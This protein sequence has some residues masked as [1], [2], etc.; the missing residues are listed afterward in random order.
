MSDFAQ[1]NIPGIPGEVRVLIERMIKELERQREAS[2]ANGLTW[3]DADK[4][5]RAAVIDGEV[6]LAALANALISPDGSVIGD[7]LLCIEESA[8]GTFVAITDGLALGRT[9]TDIPGVI[10]YNVA[11]TNSGVLGVG[12]VVARVN[13][14]DVTGKR[15]ALIDRECGGEVVAEWDLA[16]LVQPGSEITIPAFKLS[17]K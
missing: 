9:I 1:F 14:E 2:G 13:V 17:I 5:P 8:T 16:Q 3:F 10:G 4:D 12:P 7:P 15:F 11:L 6:D